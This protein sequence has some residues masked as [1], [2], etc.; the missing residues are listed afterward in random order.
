MDIPVTILQIH[1][2]ALILKQVWTL[3]FGLITQGDYKL[4][5]RLRIVMSSQ[6]SIHNGSLLH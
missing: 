5:E 1:N 6:G 3:V 4:C 2:K